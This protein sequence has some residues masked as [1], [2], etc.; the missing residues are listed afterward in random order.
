[1]P[2]PTPRNP[3]G[4][5]RKPSPDPNKKMESFWCDRDLADE[6]KNWKQIGF[7]SKAAMIN[8]A[9]KTFVEIYKHPNDED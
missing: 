5:G 7:K 1:M 9:L 8:Y 3:K 4:A 6:L 2:T